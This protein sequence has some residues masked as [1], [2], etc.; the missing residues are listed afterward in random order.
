MKQN[1][2][3]G[4]IGA[5]MVEYEKSAKELKNVVKYIDQGSFI[6]IVDSETEDPDCKSIQ[7][8]MNHV[9]KAGYGYANYIRRYF[10][11]DLTERKDDYKLSSPE[12][13]CN[14]L[15]LM[16]IYT[17]ETLNNKWNM[18][19]EKLFEINIKTTWGPEYNLEQLLEHAIVHILRHRRQ[20]EK[21]LTIS[22]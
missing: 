1:F 5:L 6:K 14:E 10:N 22:K 17:V 8:I 2:R 18:G 15:D 21:F 11:D 20:I 16:L 3:I 12:I 7:T 13:A 9:I 4:A 19:Y